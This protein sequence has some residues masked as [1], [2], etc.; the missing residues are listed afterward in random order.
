MLDSERLQEFVA[1]WRWLAAHPADDRDYY[2]QHVVPAG[3]SWKNGC[4]LATEEGEA[5]SGCRILWHGKNGSLCTDREAP[6][7]RWQ[8]TD[9][10]QA[11]LRTY[12]ASQAGT[13]GLHAIRDLKA[14]NA[15]S[16]KF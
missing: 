15:I 14:I 9:S 8:E 10:R 2:L 6:V 11:D 7:R 13:L 4:P 5:C 12:Y 3:R 1:M 16:V